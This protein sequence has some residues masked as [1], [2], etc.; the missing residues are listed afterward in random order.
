MSG[1]LAFG[2]R[3]LRSTAG[4]AALVASMGF[5]ACLVTAMLVNFL[6]EAGFVAAAAPTGLGGAAVAS[7]FFSSGLSDW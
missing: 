1:G 5:E 4:P 2:N 6:E 3:V 7:F